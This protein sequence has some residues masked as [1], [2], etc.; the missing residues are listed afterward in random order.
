MFGNSSPFYSP[1]PFSQEVAPQSWRLS[2]QDDLRGAPLQRNGM[3]RPSGKS[4]YMQRKEYSETLNRQPYDFQ[5]RVEHLFTCELDGQEM[6]TVDDCV[7]KLKSLDAKSRLWPQEMIMEVQRG[8][9]LLSDIETKVELESLSLS[10]VV[11]TKAVLDSC[12]YDS[13]LIVALKE[14][15]KRFTRVFMFQCEETGA[16]LVK[17][18]LD[19]VVQKEGGDTEPHREQ[20]DIRGNLENIIGEHAPGR[21]QQAGPHAT[22]QEWAPPPPD[23]PPP[24]WEDRQPETVHHPDL[25]QFESSPEDEQ[26]YIE[27]NTEILNHVINDLE[28]F[29][30]KVSAAVNASLLQDGKSKRKSKKKKSKKNASAASL[31]PQEEYISYLQKIR[32]GFNLLSQLDGVLTSPSAPDF[33]HIFFSTLGTIVPQYPGDLPPTVL[34]PLLTEAALQLL[35]QVVSPEEDCLWKSLGDSWN[36]PRS[37][38]PGNVPPYTPDF[39]DGWQPPALP[40][41]QIRPMSRTPPHPPP[42]AAAAAS[43]SPQDR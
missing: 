34:S 42:A 16:E 25:H 11:Q 3:F 32:Y 30:D 9:L 31:P 4:I 39:Y 33:V 29:L 35:S 20:F 37:R 15:N 23:F 8:Y 14:R 24:Q 28:I 18:D 38:Y 1:R 19:K 13:L 36:V 10:C 21:F 26:A 22:L 5:Y 7:A 43:A 27:I 6:R 40:A 2:Q 17:A 41:R 12:A